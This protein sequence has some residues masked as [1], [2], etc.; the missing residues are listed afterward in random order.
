MSNVLSVILAAGQGTRMKSDKIKVLHHVGGRPMIQHVVNS[1]TDFSS[2]IIVVVGHQSNDVNGIL[3]DKYIKFVEQREQ[4]GTGHAVIQAREYIANHNGP[5]LVLYGD[6]PLIREETLND[7]INL[8][9]NKNAACTVLTA[10]IGNPTGYGRIIRSQGGNISKIVEEKDATIKE[11]DV[12][13]INSGVCCFDS[14][15]LLEALDEIDNNNAQGEYYLTDTIS[16]LSN[17]GELVVPMI[18]DDNSEI[19]GIND[20][21][22]LFRA[23]KVLRHRINIKHMEN[24]VTIMDPD[25]TYI[26]SQVEIGRDTI[27][28]PFTY[29]EGET[30]I[31]EHC[32]I[33]PHSR[34]T[35]GQLGNYVNIKDHSIVMKSNL[36]DKTNIGPFAYIR[37]GCNVAANAK[38]GDFVEL[39]K[40]DIGDGSKVP[41]LSYVGDASI[42]KETNIGAG[43]IFA[44]YDGKEKHKTTVGNNVFIGSNTTLVAPVEISDKAKTGAGSVVTKNIK[45]GTTVVGVPAKLFKRNR[46]V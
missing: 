45:G 24:G 18:V 15:L 13:E 37:P 4:L 23:E 29:L 6:T 41:H 40:A 20:R 11:K 38:V 42:G 30:K 7:F 3:N 39:K 26:D 10:L 44:N 34:I 2:N 36:G 5:V 25:T 32:I 33:G 16:F 19:I 9:Q 21:I 22:N 14:S 31:G 8:H 12:N 28:Y 35:N 27:I 43:T 17:K 1:I 46:E